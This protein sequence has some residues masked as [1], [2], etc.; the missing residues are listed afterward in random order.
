MCNEARK[1]SFTVAPSQEKGKMD[2]RLTIGILAGFVCLALALIAK[3][4]R[5]QKA[6]KLRQ[7]EE[8]V[9]KREEEEARK[10]RQR[11]EEARKVKTQREEERTRKRRERAAEAEKQLEERLKEGIK[12]SLAKR[13]G[14]ALGLKFRQLV[15][16]GEYGRLNFDRWDRELTDFMQ[17]V[18]KMKTTDR[19]YNNTRSLL[20]RIAREAAKALPVMGDI[21]EVRSGLAY[22]HF[23]AKCFN[24]IGWQ[25]VIT[26]ASGD[27]GAD[28]KI[29]RG[30]IDG[31]VQCKWHQ[32]AVGNKAVQEIAAA[33]N[34]YGVRHA[35]VVAKSGYT[36]AAKELAKT[37]GVFLIHHDEIPE[38]HRRLSV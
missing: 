30:G 20:K 15:V 18:L 6:R 21:S 16:R 13:Y 38:L 1:A 25:T 35:I 23:V 3:K 24:D 26:K 19:N 10:V 17:N 5:D 4:L 2:V 36:E 28:V 9:K 12:R 29:L 33:R 31:V 22:E 37:N 7:R 27:Q 14:K 34:H 32:N 11:E 8:E